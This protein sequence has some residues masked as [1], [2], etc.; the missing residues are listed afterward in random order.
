MTLPVCLYFQPP[1][2]ISLLK[3]PHH[4]SNESANSGFYQ[5]FRAEVYIICGSDHAQ[6]SGNPKFSSLKAMVSGFEGKAVS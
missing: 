1:L 5:K 3:I 6:E 4:G 2:L